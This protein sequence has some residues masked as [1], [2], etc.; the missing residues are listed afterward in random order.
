MLI[1]S[2]LTII[3]LS[4]AFLLGGLNTNA[5]STYVELSFDKTVKKADAPAGDNR[6]S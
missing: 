5:S 1:K 4:L 6:T 3:I 2:K